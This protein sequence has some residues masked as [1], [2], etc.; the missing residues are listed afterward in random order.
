MGQS[1]TWCVHRVSLTERCVECERDTGK[2]WP[3][4]TLVAEAVLADAVR[5]SA[6][7][8]TPALPTDSAE[9][10]RTPLC[11]GLLDYAPDALREIASAC[12]DF[13]AP[14]GEIED[15]ILECLANRGSRT[16]ARSTLRGTFFA[17][18]MLESELGGG[19]GSEDR[20]DWEYEDWS[21]CHTVLDLF[22]LVPR[23]MAAIAQVSWHGN[24]KHN[25]GQP[26]HHAR[27]KSADH[28]DCILRHLLEAGGFDGPFRHTAAQC[29]RWLMLGQ[30]ECEANGAPKAR[31]AR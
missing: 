2:A 4:Q 17:L 26:L 6:P 14:E 19:H 29:W 30:E 23:A 18:L 25:P 28:A 9:R 16:C 13:S 24:E 27:G 8:P 3:L 31:G 22:A 5:T 15:E 1:N 20:C 7:A 10:K 21:T 12:S 11:S